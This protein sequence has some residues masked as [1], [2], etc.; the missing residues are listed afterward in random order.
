LHPRALAEDGLEAALAAL[1]A[2]VD[3]AGQLTIAL[4]P[5]V[6]VDLLAMA[7]FVCSEAVT[8]VVKHAQA[9]SVQVAV[10]RSAAG[11]LL[12]E[13]SDDGCGGAAFS[14]GSGLSGLADRV[15]SFGGR[16][17]LESPPGGGTRLTVRVPRIRD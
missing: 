9:S 14:A 5:G 11:E 17:V 12:V 13:V 6:P 10:C 15:T 7:Y 2:D 3:V 16:L 8:N 1:L 4:T